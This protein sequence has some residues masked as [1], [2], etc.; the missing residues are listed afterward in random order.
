M[1]ATQPSSSRETC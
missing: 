1:A